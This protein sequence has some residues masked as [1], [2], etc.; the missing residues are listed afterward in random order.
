M[1]KRW[2]PELRTGLDYQEVAPRKATRLAWCRLGPAGSDDL[3]KA[4]RRELW[5][6]LAEMPLLAACLVDVDPLL[7]MGVRFATI[8]ADHPVSPDHG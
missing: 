4:T 2:Y 6:L 3:A 7:P 5:L 8:A 1:A